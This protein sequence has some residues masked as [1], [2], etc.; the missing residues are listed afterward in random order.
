MFS[1]QSEGESGTDADTANSR[2]D[3]IANRKKP[4]GPSLLEISCLLCVGAILLKIP[5]TV[6]DL[7][8]WIQ[9]G[10]LLY[11]RAAKEIPLTMR[12]RLPGHLQEQLE[13]QTL[14]SPDV[15]HRNVLILLSTFSTD[16]GMAV[17]PINQP[18]VLYRFVTELCLPLEIYVAVQRLARLMDLEF[19]YA[20]DAKSWSNMSL[21]FPEIRLMALVVIATKLLFPF[22]DTRRYAASASDLGALQMDWQLWADLHRLDRDT[23]EGRGA[24]DRLSFEDAFTMTEA[25]SLELAGDRLD[26]YLRW[27]EANIA[28]E[29]VR[30]RGRAGREA[31]FRRTLFKLFPTHSS[32][33][34]ARAAQSGNGESGGI[35]TD[36]LSQ[37]QSALQPKRIVKESESDDVPRAGSSYAQHRDFE[38]LRGPLRAFYGSAARVA[39][40]SGRGLVRAVFLLER[41]LIRMGEEMQ[42]T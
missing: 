19:A 25:E 41:K 30:A 14:V 38:E 22:D 3:R 16:F 31:D 29:E 13:P 2:R 7:Y 4:K 32:S 42:R 33:S 23:E 40:F 11:Y 10:D 8:Q 21:R 37:V 34:D 18:L 28:S 35:S 1:S 5:L 6:A 12:D 36:R 39:G 27:Y 20:V 9:N 15:F 17:S 26:Q 24:A